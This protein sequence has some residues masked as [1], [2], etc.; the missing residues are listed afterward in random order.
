MTFSGI[1]LS[2]FQPAATCHEAFIVLRNFA[3]ASQISRDGSTS[4]RYAKFASSRRSGPF[5][6]SS[7]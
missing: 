5:M 7:V 3:C 6:T 4:H 2:E 1:S